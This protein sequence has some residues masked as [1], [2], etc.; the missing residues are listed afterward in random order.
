MLRYYSITTGSESP[1]LASRNS[2]FNMYSQT[3]I[4]EVVK[5]IYKIDGYFI[6]I[7]LDLRGTQLKML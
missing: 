7:F 5:I 3:I 4:L 6:Y 1:N 2:H